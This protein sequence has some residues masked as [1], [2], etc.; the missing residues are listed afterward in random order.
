MQAQLANQGAT[1]QA[2]QAGMAAGLS[3]EALAAQQKQ[4][5]EFANMQAQNQAKGFSAQQQQAAQFSNQQATNRASEFGSSQALNAALA[6]QQAGNRAA[7]FGVQ[8]GLGQEQAQAG[9]AQQANLANLASE[10]QRQ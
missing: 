3:Q 5:Q 1:N 4:A 9:F 7:E 10:Q 6:N 8:A 2:L